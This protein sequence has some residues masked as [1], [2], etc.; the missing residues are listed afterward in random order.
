MLVRAGL[1]YATLIGAV[2]VADVPNDST[3][4][5]RRLFSADVP[6]DSTVLSGLFVPTGHL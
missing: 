4:L 2:L 3:V 1:H 5:S 6:N